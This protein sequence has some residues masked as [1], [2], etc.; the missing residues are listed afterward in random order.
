MRDDEEIYLVDDLIMPAEEEK[1][2]HVTALPPVR[3]VKV[4]YYSM[5]II[6]VAL[7]LGWQFI[8]RK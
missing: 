4:L 5:I 3:L 7:L 8:R 1:P 6:L 2:V